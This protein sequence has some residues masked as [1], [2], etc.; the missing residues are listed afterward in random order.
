[1]LQKINIPEALKVAGFVVMVGAAFFAP[2]S[3]QVPLFMG[4]V[5][6]LVGYTWGKL[7]A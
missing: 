3:N 5:A 7:T 6:V 2:I 1:M 4:A